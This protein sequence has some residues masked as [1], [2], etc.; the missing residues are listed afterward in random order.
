MSFKKT[1][2]FFVIFLLLG[3][4]Y[5][6]VEVRLAGKK[7]AAEEAGKKLFRMAAENIQEIRLKR[8][9]EEIVL[10]KQA[11]GWQLSQPVAAAADAQTVQSLLDGLVA[12]QRDKT[13]TAKPADVQDFGLD[14]PELVVTLKAQESGAEERLSIGKETPTASGWYARI[15]D[16]P[17][18][19]TISASVKTTLDKTLYEL[20]DKTILAFEPAKLKQVTFALKTPDAATPQEITLE[21][22][23]DRW[24]IIAPKAYQADTAKMGALLS[25][26]QSARIKTFIAED[27]KDL[28]QYGLDQPGTTVSLGMGADQPVKT[29]LIGKSDAQNSGFYAKQAAAGNV[30]V[31]PAELV[32][33]FPKNPND[34][35]DKTLLAF[36]DDKLRKIELASA[37]ETVVLERAAEEWKITQ[38]AEFE[39]DQTKIVTLLADARTVQVTQFLPDNAANLAS[40]GLEP[41]QLQLRFWEQGPP[42]PQQLLLGHADAQNTGIYAK[43]GA[44]N[45]VVLVKPDVLKQL[46]KTAFDLRY[47]KILAVDSEQIE[48]LQL[49]YP[50]L[51]MLLEK[52]GTAWQAT[53]PEKQEVLAYK[54]NN[55]LYDLAALEFQAEIPTPTADGSVYGFDKPAAEITFWAKGAQNGTTLLI[56]KNVEGQE[57]LY[58]KTSASAAVYAIAPAFLAE[59]PKDLKT[60]AE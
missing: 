56:G 2:I 22:T 41:P 29:L 20:R 13:I 37:K 51:T 55:V 58:A 14:Q 48:K 25:N 16:G 50:N 6:F 35:R 15:G 32:A 17:A 54:V 7:Q 36:Q 3:G 19:M 24:K 39:A 1:L 30:F 34:L 59:L 45:T 27:S 28:A 11:Q 33:A 31:I 42:Q 47:R 40:Y 52:N 18:I 4:Y 23:E 44:Q 57:R 12:A 46:T 21:Q 8:P 26:L 5:Y 60:L 9:T 10:Q 43:L 38:P 49:K 53:M